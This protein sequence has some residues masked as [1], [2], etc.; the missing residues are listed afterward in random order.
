M[1]TRNKINNKEIRKGFQPLNRVE[2]VLGAFLKHEYIPN[3][4]LARGNNGFYDAGDYKY[5]S[6]S[7]TKNHNEKRALMTQ[8]LEKPYIFTSRHR[9]RSFKIFS[10]M[11]VRKTHEHKI[12]QALIARPE[13]AYRYWERWCLFKD[14]TILE[15]RLTEKLLKK[16]EVQCDQKLREENDYLDELL[17]KANLIE[18]NTNAKLSSISTIDAEDEIPF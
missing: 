1:T 7:K 17:S 14:G 10:F 4:Y 6:Y 13:H 5:I 3:G 9:E 12:I 2:L 18:R 16:I 11:H 8:V 15:P